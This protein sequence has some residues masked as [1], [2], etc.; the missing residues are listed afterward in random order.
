[1][2]LYRNKCF[3]K[4]YLIKSHCN[5]IFDYQ[6]LLNEIY[7]AEPLPGHHANPLKHS[8]A[9]DNIWSPP[10]IVEIKATQDDVRVFSTVIKLKFYDTVTCIL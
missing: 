2:I 8:S 4:K 9:E 7:Q 5:E 10:K 3:E 1:M 6:I